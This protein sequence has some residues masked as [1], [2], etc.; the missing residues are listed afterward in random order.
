MC[1]VGRFKVFV[2]GIEREAMRLLRE[3]ITHAWGKL[4]PVD[5]SP[6]YLVGFLSIAILVFV[7]GFAIG[8]L[9]P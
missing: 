9:A 7:L 6:S 4:N 8:A 3:K 2:E 1:A 5:P